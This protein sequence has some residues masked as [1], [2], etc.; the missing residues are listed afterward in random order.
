MKAE[1]EEEKNDIQTNQIIAFVQ[2]LQEKVAEL[3]TDEEK[4][5]QKK[6]ANEAVEWKE[7][8]KV[9]EMDVNAERRRRWRQSRRR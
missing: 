5:I 1:E 6:E 8:L 2:Y 7:E 3:T 4:I 9:K